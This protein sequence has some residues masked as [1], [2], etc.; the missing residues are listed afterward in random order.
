MASYA[1]AVGDRKLGWGCTAAFCLRALKFFLLL[2]FAPRLTCI[3]PSAPPSLSPP[4]HV[5][6]FDEYMNV[7]LDDA[8]EIN[9]KKKSRTPLGRILLK[10]ENITLVHTVKEA[11]AGAA[12]A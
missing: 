9:L 1:S 6:G 8:V 11:G 4:L 2:S 12:V 5:Q 7:V 10:G 3:V